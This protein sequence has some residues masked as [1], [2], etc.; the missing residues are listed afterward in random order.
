[1]SENSTNVTLVPLEQAHGTVMIVAWVVCASTG[2]L[3]AR[4]FR[5]LRFGDRRTLLRA[6]IWFQTHRAFF[7][8]AAIMT[9][10]RSSTAL[11]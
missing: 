8:L 11:Y 3:F 9:T 10:T 7:L 4:Y 5:H 1:M 6:D 2:I